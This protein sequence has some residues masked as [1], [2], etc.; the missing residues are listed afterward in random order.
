MTSA[1][2]LSEG[3]GLGEVRMTAEI[4]PKATQPQGATLDDYGLGNKFPDRGVWGPEPSDPRRVALEACVLQ[5][6][7][8]WKTRFGRHH[9]L[10]GKPQPSDPLPLCSSGISTMILRN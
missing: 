7:A 2:G 8:G 6:E 1:P 10:S 3:L 9:E 4:G 5:G